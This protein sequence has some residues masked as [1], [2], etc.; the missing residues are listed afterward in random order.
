MTDPSIR[1]GS[2]RNSATRDGAWP[3][4]AARAVSLAEA[5]SFLLLLIAT[6]VKHGADHEIGVKILGPVHGG[7]FIAYCLLVLYVGS[8]RRWPVKRTLLALGASVLP[9]APF[10]V[11]RHW[12]REPAPASDGAAG[13]GT[14]EHG[15]SPGRASSAPAS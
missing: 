15:G 14:S 11:E 12:L 8:L 13:H 4:G 3:M 2:T 1:D 6:A 9:V 5:T 10:F 7:L